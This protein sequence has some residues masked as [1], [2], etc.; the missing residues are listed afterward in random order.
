M[1]FVE[2]LAVEYFTALAFVWFVNWFLNVVIGFNH[3]V[4][5]RHLL[6]ASF[7]TQLTQLLQLRHAH[8]FFTDCIELRLQ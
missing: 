3:L 2:M 4:S 5:G 8:I 1:L 6:V 7:L